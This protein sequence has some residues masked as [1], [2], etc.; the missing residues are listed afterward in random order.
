MIDID[1]WDEL[2][3][4][5]QREHEDPYWWYHEVLWQGFREKQLTYIELNEFWRLY[6]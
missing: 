3:N 1:F 4:S 2:W 5:R 6:W